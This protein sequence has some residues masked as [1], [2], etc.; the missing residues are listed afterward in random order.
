MPV[1]SCQAW[2]SKLDKRDLSKVGY[3]NYSI[4]FYVSLMHSTD[5][6]VIVLKRTTIFYA[7]SWRFK[8]IKFRSGYFV[9]ES[10]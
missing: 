3:I 5:K 9:M 4:Y 1:I 7:F 10:T 2:N 8:K 6:I